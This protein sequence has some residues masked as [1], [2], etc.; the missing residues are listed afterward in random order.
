MKVNII[1]AGITGLSLAYFLTKKGYKVK[2]FDSAHEVGGLAGFF[3]VSDGKYLEKYY[4]HVFTGHV[5]LIQ[6]LKELN[7]E[8]DLTF[9]NVKMGFFYGG[10]IYPFVTARDLLSFHPLKLR[11]RIRLGLTSLIMKRH[12]DWKDLEKNSALEWL[13]RYS[14]EEASKIIWEPLLRMKFG[15]D[16]NRISAAWIWNRVVDRKRDGGGKDVL[17]Y[18]SQGYKSIFDSLIQYIEQHDGKVETKAPV[19]EICIENGRCTGIRSNGKYFDGDVAI[20]TIPIP[21]F[22][23]IAPSLPEVYKKTLSSIKYQGLICLVL[24]LKKSLSDYYWINVS[25]SNCPFV[26]VIE[27]T[28]F[29]SPEHY[30]NRHL[31]YLSKYSSSESNIFSKSEEQVYS[32]FIV[33]LKRIFPH[34]EEKDVEKYWIFKDRLSQ[35]VFIKNYSRIMPEIRTPIHNL[36]LL[37][38]TQ[39]YPES[40]S[41]NSSIARAYNVVK[42][43]VNEHGG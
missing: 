41:V 4:H 34:F 10:K 3:H 35:P 43:V 27:H 9:S 7:M 17:G 40:R 29:I 26:A 14:G 16:Y 32:D 38:T 24:Q 37:N 5:E 30:G 36:Y 12:S 18:L 22:L 6:L 23:H 11:N 19:E 25:D 13:Y 2:V 33:H 1:G 42:E 20:S 21:S 39:F 8:N 28:R 31:V 15:D